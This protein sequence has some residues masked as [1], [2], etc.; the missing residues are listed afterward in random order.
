MKLEEEHKIIMLNNFVLFISTIIFDL[1]I[2]ELM[3]IFV[4]QSVMVLF[5]AVGRMRAL[6]KLSIIGITVNNRSIEPT[7]KEKN[8]LTFLFILHFGALNAAYTLLVMSKTHDVYSLG[9]GVTLFCAVITFFMYLKKKNEIFIENDKKEKINI[10]TLMV[11]PYLRVIPMHLTIIFSAFYYNGILMF[12]I[13]KCIVEIFIDQ[14]ERK[15]LQVVKGLDKSR[16]L[17]KINAIDYFRLNLNKE[18]IY[19]IRQDIFKTVNIKNYDDVMC[20]ENCKKNIIYKLFSY[21]YEKNNNFF[22]KIIFSKEKFFNN[23]FNQIKENKK[24]KE[25]IDFILKEN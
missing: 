8:K 1:T 12:L 16:D 23:F 3:A 7:E 25:I 22:L 13:L 18:D 24:E 4:I 19:I 14:I 6:D 11:Y 17:K 20:D 21:N 10:G 15:K 2:Y 9:F 5:F